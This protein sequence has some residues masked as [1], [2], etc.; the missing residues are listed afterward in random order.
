[1]TRVLVALICSGLML[2]AA[3][4]FASAGDRVACGSA[5]ILDNLTTFTWTAWVNQ[6][7]TTDAEIIVSKDKIGSRG[8][9]FFDDGGALRLQRFTSGSART[10][11]SNTGFLSAN[12]WHFAAVTYDAAATPRAR[13]YVGGLATTVA[14]VTY[15]TQDA[16]S[17]D[18]NDDSGNS[19]VIS[20][21]DDAAT[22]VEWHG[23]IADVR[24]FN[25]VLTLG[26]LRA[27]QFGG[28]SGLQP[29]F[30]NPLYFTANHGDLSGQAHA[31]V[32]TA[33]TQASH[34]PLGR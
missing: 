4:T 26:Q 7:D 3:L 16:G 10:Y 24:G 34:V 23:R 19:L 30:Y 13:I 17:G 1:M 14:E 6:A 28:R 33:A 15:A 20:E 31:C 25:T 21:L 22:G 9:L 12:T 32:V 27:I 11:D 5:A 2:K 8:W 18:D 29:I